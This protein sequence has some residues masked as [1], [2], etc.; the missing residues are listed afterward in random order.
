MGNRLT[1]DSYKKQTKINKISDQPNQSGVMF[2]RN[3]QFDKRKVSINN[4]RLDSSQI[5]IS[6]FSTQ[7]NESTNNPQQMKQ[8]MFQSRNSVGSYMTAGFNQINDTKSSFYR[9]GTTHLQKKPSEYSQSQNERQNRQF[10]VQ[11]SIKIK[12]KENQVVIKTKRKC[13]VTRK[14]FEIK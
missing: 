13:C 12:K 3:S 4:S 2:K 5:N 8:K 14:E 10:S 6:A 11:T 9:P 7:L 1:R